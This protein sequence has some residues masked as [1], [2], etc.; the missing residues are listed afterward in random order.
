MSRRQAEREK[1]PWA[2][3]AP[4]SGQCCIRVL[5]VPFSEKCGYAARTSM[6]ER[7]KKAP[8][9]P[10]PRATVKA[11]GGTPTVRGL[12]RA[13]EA[14]QRQVE[15]LE[16]LAQAKSDFVATVSHDLRTPLH[17]I[18]GYTDLLLEGVFGVLES[19][20]AETLRRIAERTREVLDLVKA[21]LE[22]SELERAGLPADLDLADLLRGVAAAVSQQ[23]PG[24]G[25]ELRWKVAPDAGRVRAEAHQLESVLLRLIDNAMKFTPRGHVSIEASAGENGVDL[26]VSDTGLGIE[27]ARLPTI[28]QP[29]AA[30]ETSAPNAENGTGL[31]LYAVRHLVSM[32]GGAISVKSQLGRG[33][34]FRIWLPAA[35][36]PKCGRKPR[37][38]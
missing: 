32:L 34:T 8:P 22:L 9:A 16:R 38:G 29:F 30:G 15:E 18:I 31:G 5:T 27:A 28:F 7:R 35:P 12:E 11:R 36:S 25:V 4:A 13:L 10:K 24:S 33:S 2:W 21:T 23:H 20:Q 1:A 26:V 3:R 14:R 37:R 19:Q 6:K 17:V